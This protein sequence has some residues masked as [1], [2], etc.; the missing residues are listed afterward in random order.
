MAN[1][2]PAKNNCKLSNF[3]KELF[4]EVGL[5]FWIIINVAPR[6]IGIA[7]ADGHGRNEEF[8]PPKKGCDKK[9]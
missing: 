8:Q 2:T 3:E 1:N 9:K 6:S 5:S 4:L 7:K